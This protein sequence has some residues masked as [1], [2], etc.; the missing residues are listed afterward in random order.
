MKIMY[1]V[2][3]YF[4]FLIKIKLPIIHYYMVASQLILCVIIEHLLPNCWMS[5]GLKLMIAEW[6][7]FSVGFICNW[8]LN[9]VWRPRFPLESGGY[10]LIFMGLFEK[11]RNRRFWL[12][13]DPEILILTQFLLYFTRNCTK[14]LITHPK[15]TTLE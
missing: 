1:G 4:G 8:S 13:D 3:A 9:W 15:L 12:G 10:L 14:Q 11:L 2:P 7:G 5:F 6:K